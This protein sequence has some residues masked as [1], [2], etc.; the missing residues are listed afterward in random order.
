MAEASAASTAHA[1]AWDAAAEAASEA[2]A[3]KDLADA[4]K[5]PLVLAM[6]P[7][8]IHDAPGLCVVCVCLCVCS[9]MCVYVHSVCIDFTL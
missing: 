2:A 6:P 9:C 1:V 3:C 7:S 8:L 4:L 5:L